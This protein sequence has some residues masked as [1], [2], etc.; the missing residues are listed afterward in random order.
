MIRAIILAIFFTSLLSAKIVI[1]SFNV[2]NLFD[3]K[4]DGTEYADFKKGGKKN[5]NKEKFEKK[6][7]AVSKDIKDIDADVILLLEI[8]NQGVL[9]ELASRTGYKYIAFSKGNNEAPVGLGYLSKKEI[10][11]IKEYAVPRV[12]TRPILQIKV[13]EAGREL[14]LF[15]AHFPAMKNS[16]EKRL[17]AAKTMLRAVHGV[18]NVIILGDLNSNWDDKF[19]LKELKNDYTSI[20]QYKKGW[21][22]YKSGGTIDHIMLSNDL[23]RAVSADFWVHKTKSSD[24]N[25]LSVKF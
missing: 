23:A 18:K 10:L 6:I 14:N 3:D 2:N 16:L 8:E 20:W 13:R 22:S 1:A 7:A 15:G 21:D 9:K 11:S 4:I 12:K 19:L 5:W 24:H 25:A 17:N